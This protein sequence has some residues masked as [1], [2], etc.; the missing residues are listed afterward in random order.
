VL[1]IP[2]RRTVLQV[3][4]VVVGLVAVLVIDPGLPLG[5]RANKSKHHQFMDKPTAH[6]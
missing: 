2:L 4:E 1:T 3:A 6:W 5:W